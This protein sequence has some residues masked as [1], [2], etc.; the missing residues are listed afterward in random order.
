[1]AKPNIANPA[2]FPERSK[3]HT[4]NENSSVRL[5]VRALVGAQETYQEIKKKK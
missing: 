3:G 5:R 2:S 1:M 4:F